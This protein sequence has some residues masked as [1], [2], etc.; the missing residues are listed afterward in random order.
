MSESKTPSS[1]LAQHEPII[2]LVGF[3]GTGKTTFLKQLVNDSLK[4][5]AKP[6]VI[7]NDYQ[8]ALFDSQ[9]FSEKLGSEFVE[10]VNG[11]CICCTGIHELRASVNQIPQRQ[12]GLTIIEANGT[13]DACTLMEFLSVG[14]EDRFA[15]PIQI[16]IVSV[17]EWQ[18]RGLDNELEA[19]QVQVSSLILLNQFG[20]S[21]KEKAEKVTA[22]LKQ[23]NPNA[24]IID[25]EDF[26]FS[27]VFQL[28]PSTNS[29]AKMDHK[30]SH[31]SSCSVEIPDPISSEKLRHVLNN[32]PQSIL[33]VKGC[34]RLDN[35]EHYTMFERIPNQEVFARPCSYEPITGPKMIAVGPGSNPEKL[36]E[37]F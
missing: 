11:S 1:S 31:W 7:I 29:P 22:D 23:L 32:I 37:L 24:K 10:T 35:D 3:L 6:F 26:K 14:I 4:A 21:E 28:I 13:S 5:E 16:S 2:A 30:K 34:T 33:R 36:T 12:N 15:P 19:N 17:A 25:M 27:D 18:K 9:Q 8:N 20:N